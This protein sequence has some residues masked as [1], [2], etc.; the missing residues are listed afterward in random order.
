M[1]T[2]DADNTWKALSDPTRRAI[3]DVLRDGP[4]Q[5]T[6]I[7]E[8]FPEL[9]R[10]AVMKHLEVLRSA[11]LV[12]TRSEGR[13]RV[14]AL[15]AAPIRDILERWISKYESFWSNTLLRVRD[16]AENKS[17]RVNS[18]KRNSG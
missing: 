18:K 10:F 6:A 14:N 16:D 17:Q 12:N 4:K 1:K 9:S 2:D 13:V 7:V 11:K 3:L 15:N 5:T 8:R